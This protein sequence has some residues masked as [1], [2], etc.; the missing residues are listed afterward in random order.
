M[1]C[2]TIKNGVHCTFMSSSGCGFTGG[3]CLSV[4]ESCKGCDR[5]S[6]YAT[7]EYCNSYPNPSV[8]WEFGRCNFATHLKIEKQEAKKLNPLKASKRSAGGKK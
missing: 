3:S 2:T 4:V 8:K 6:A 7:G 1:N 5:I